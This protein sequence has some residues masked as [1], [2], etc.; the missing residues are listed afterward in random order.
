MGHVRLHDMGDGGLP[1]CGVA[2]PNRQNK[3]KKEVL[4]CLRRICSR[5]LSPIV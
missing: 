3:T 5:P 4:T 1:A 2:Q